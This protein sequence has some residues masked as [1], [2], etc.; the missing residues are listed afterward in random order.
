MQSPNTS[1]FAQPAPALPPAGEPKLRMVR[2]LEER[3]QQKLR[4][5]GFLH[6]RTETDDQGEIAVYGYYEAARPTVRRHELPVRA[7][8]VLSCDCKWHEI[9]GHCAHMVALQRQIGE[10]DILAD[11]LGI[12][13]QHTSPIPPPVN[14]SAFDEEERLRLQTDPAYRR[15]RLKQIQEEW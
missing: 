4:D 2:P 5:G 12:S 6:E 13:I 11:D 8:V 15:A 3:V 9:H 7:G 1:Q 14:P 10:P